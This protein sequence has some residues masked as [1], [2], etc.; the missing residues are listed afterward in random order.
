MIAEASNVTRTD[1]EA[2]ELI[3][4]YHQ[5]GHELRPCSAAIGLGSHD[6]GVAA[7]AAKLY[8][9]S[10]FPVM[11]FSG[12]INAETSRWMPRG[13]AV[14]FRERAIELGVPSSAILLEPRATNTGEN[15]AFSR[16]VLQEAGIEVSSV[17]LLAMPY[18]QR[19]AYAT[20]RKLWPQVVPVCASEPVDFIA[21]VTGIGDEAHVIHQIVGDLQRVI[22]YPRLGYAIDQP[23]PEDVHAAYTY[24]RDRGY[25]SRI[26][27]EQ[28]TYEQR[29]HLRDTPGQAVSAISDTSQDLHG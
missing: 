27:H 28:D 16:R 17:M 7:F 6:I 1:R 12:A 18:M 11:V 5:L 25:T 29:G 19:R 3:W 2:A 14:Q 26:I 23:V 4:H 13:E 15:I 22:A 20:C 24:L 21:Y 8:H 9:E 10:V